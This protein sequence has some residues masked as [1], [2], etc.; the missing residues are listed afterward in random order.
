MESSDE[1]RGG[2][3]IRAAFLE[4]VNSSFT[5]DRAASTRPALPAAFTDRERAGFHPRSRR[6]RG[7]VEGWFRRETG[8]REPTAGRGKDDADKRNVDCIL[9]MDPPAAMMNV[10]SSE[11]L[12]TPD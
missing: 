12:A 4:T 10:T 9:R 11:P 5:D 8:N 3:V 6:M 7:A 2:A 1:G